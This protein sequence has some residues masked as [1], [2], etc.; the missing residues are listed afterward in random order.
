MQTDCL[1]ASGWRIFRRSEII[2]GPLYQTLWQ[3]SAFSLDDSFLIHRVQLDNHQFWVFFFF[4]LRFYNNI[5]FFKLHAKIF[6]RFY[7]PPPPR[8][9]VIGCLISN[10]HLTNRQNLIQPCITYTM[11][12]FSRHLSA[13]C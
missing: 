12:Y 4:N 9:F 7:N 5:L 11:E 3:A 13:V 10:F 1:C 2:I 8:I 6:C